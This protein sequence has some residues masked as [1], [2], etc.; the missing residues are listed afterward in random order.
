MTTEVKC[1]F[2][3]VQPAPPPMAPMPMFTLDE[4]IAGHPVNSTVTLATILGAGHHAPFD[5]VTKAINELRK[6]NVPGG[7]EYA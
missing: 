4:E 1:R 6:H 7:P 2:A 3:H 5:E